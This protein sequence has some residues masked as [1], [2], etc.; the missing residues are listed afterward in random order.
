MRIEKVISLIGAF[1]IIGVGMG[2]AHAVAMNPQI[3]RLLQEKQD[4]IAELE[5]CEGKKQGFM[6]AGIS[7]IGLTVGG[8]ALNIVQANKSN[9]LSDEIDQ[10]RQ[11]LGN[12]E[13]ELAGVRADIAKK[14]RERRQAECEAQEGKRWTEDGRCVDDVYQKASP[15]VRP[16]DLYSGYQL[17]CSNTS[18][19]FY[20]GDD[21]GPILARLNADCQKV[22]GHDM[23]TLGARD[24]KIVYE[25][26]G[27]KDSIDCAQSGGIV[28]MGGIIGQPCAEGIQNIANSNFTGVW[29]IDAK[30]QYQCKETPN[31]TIPVPCACKPGDGGIVPVKPQGNLEKCLA[32]RKNAGKEALACCYAEEQKIATWTGS[33]CRCNA[34]NTKFEI[35]ADGKGGKCVSNDDGTILPT[36]VLGENCTSGDLPA[37]STSGKYVVGQNWDCLESKSSK[38]IVKCSCSPTVCDNSRGFVL[39]NGECVLDDLNPIPPYNKQD[40]ENC[41]KSGGEWRLVEKQKRYECFCGINQSA[42]DKNM[43]QTAGFKTCACKKDH[44]YIDE[45]DHS[46]GCKRGIVPQENQNL[47]KIV[48]LYGKFEKLV[49]SMDTKAIQAE[50]AATAAGNA[51]KAAD[52]RNY[53]NQAKGYFDEVE[54]KFREASGLYDEI[55][56]L[57]SGLGQDSKPTVSEYK[58]DADTLNAR[59]D[60]IVSKARNA[61]S[62]AEQAAVALE[63]LARNNTCSSSQCRKCVDTGG[64]WEEQVDGTAFCRCDRS[65]GLVSDSSKMLYCKPANGS[66]ASSSANTGNNSSNFTG[67]PN[68]K[69][70]FDMVRTYLARECPKCVGTYTSTMNAAAEWDLNGMSQ[71]DTIASSGGYSTIKWERTDSSN[72]VFKIYANDGSFIWLFCPSKCGKSV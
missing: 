6:I 28:L 40:A 9:R 63:N 35:N 24:G 25:C 69:Y 60:S 22:M 15:I 7:T 29:T 23:V 16:L 2:D 58:T 53:A 49:D 59:L 39:K 48:D 71:C 42:T 43:V 13:I 54:K 27:Y 11:D 1:A 20:E 64:K 4:K 65:K 67:D 26:F 31:S 8:V 10:A 46:K 52:A 51:S 19:E 70:C 55:N 38:K 66:S 32:N 56:R 45:N 62:K 17:T 72:T 12:K 61:A 34:A 3:R 68:V 41:V 50:R 14:D 37:N 44:V 30:G 57:Y 5:K 21:I 33:I 47:N 36:R 18:F